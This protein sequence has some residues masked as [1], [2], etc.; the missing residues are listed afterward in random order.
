LGKGKSSTKVPLVG[1]IYVAS[2]EGNQLLSWI[3][4]NGS[5]TVVECHPK[6]VQPSHLHVTF[7]L[8]LLTAGN[9]ASKGALKKKDTKTYDIAHC[10][11]T[12]NTLQK[13]QLISY[14]MQVSISI[15]ILL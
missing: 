3:L 1:G 12:S 6:L 2:K 7:A 11:Y 13:P 10:N 8:P 14:A 9:F 5:Y 15:S 4:V